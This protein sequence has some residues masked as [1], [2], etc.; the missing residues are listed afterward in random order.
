M[1][2]FGEQLKRERTLRKISLEEIAKATKISVRYL[3]ALEGNDFSELPGGVFDRGYVRAYAQF[4]GLDEEA[5]VEAYV[6]ER[7]PE[8]TAEQR[9]DGLDALRNAVETQTGA[10]DSEGGDRGGN[11]RMLR[12]AA[13]VV[14]LVG[15]VSVTAW[16]VSRYLR[17]ADAGPDLPRQTA[18]AASPPASTVEQRPE[19]SPE[20]EPSTDTPTEL[21]VETIP[22]E[23][24]ETATANRPAADQVAP[25]PEATPTPPATPPIEVAQEPRAEGAPIE[26][27]VLIDRAASGRINCD[28][29]RVEMLEGLRPGTVL[30]LRCQ[31][32]LI[33]NVRDGGAVRVGLNGD[34]PMRLAA[35][36]EAL[37]DYGIYP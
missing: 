16:A 37:D 22:E 2:S 36:G 25:E 10:G 14:V 11:R 33:L 23:A 8:P 13:L 4:V 9:D 29:R 27:R 19:R 34:A 24:A 31:R 12:R 17:S 35:D 6:A 1:S 26:A 32:F 5:T 7:G 28:N 18:A 3:R 30:E 20:P 21:V 15:A